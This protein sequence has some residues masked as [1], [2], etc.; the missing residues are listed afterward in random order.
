MSKPQPATEVLL[1]IDARRPAT[2]ARGR[3]PALLHARAPSLLGALLGVMSAAGFLTG[4]L[5]PNGGETGTTVVMLGSD[6]G[7]TS[8]STSDGTTLPPIM[9][10]TEEP[11]TTDEPGSG[12]GDDTTAGTSSST[13]TTMDPGTC[14]DGSLNPGEQCDAGPE[15]SDEGLCT[16]T[17][18]S[19]KCGDGFVQPG[20]VCDNG[21][22]DNAYGGCA[23]GCVALGPHCGDGAV[24]EDIE[25]CDGGDPWDAVSGCLLNCQY[26]QSC[27]QIREAFPDD[28]TLAD[29]VYT[30]KRPNKSPAQVFCEMDTDGGGYTYLKVALPEGGAEFTAAKA[31]S[32]CGE[33][34]M[35]LLVPRTPTH[36]IASTLVAKSGLLEPVGGG[37]TKGN[38][39][40]MTMLGIYPA[41]PGKSCVDKALNSTECPQWTAN[42]G[43]YHV[44][45]VPI[46]GQPNVTNCY[47]C[48]MDYSWA[49]DGTVMYYEAIMAGGDG[50]T[51]LRF[52]CDPGDKLGLNK[53]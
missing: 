53:G 25:A 17:C 29:G 38:I 1:S 33:F 19:A 52:M 5:S 24:D 22:N 43:T 7:S 36:L 39:D 14:G 10:T 2:E 27:K 46:M 8:D 35:R 21:V 37:T 45:A 4:C 28:E 3:A 32:K 41:I 40:Y 20:E 12:S 48:S 44:T 50:A 16:S 23:P 51:A 34:G 13:E 47:K 26:A 6:T 15:N 18:T 49:E 31:E 42:G 11:E 9:T 30:I